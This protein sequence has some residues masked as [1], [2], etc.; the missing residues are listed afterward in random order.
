[1]MDTLAGNAPLREYADG[2]MLAAK[3]GGIGFVTF[4][5]PEKRNAMSVEMWQGLAEIL[6]DFR[7]DPAVR[8]V[9]MTG[10]G[11]Q[12][13]VCMLQGVVEFSESARF[14]A[15]LGTE[16]AA[17]SAK[18]FIISST[19]TD[20]SGLMLSRLTR[21]TAPLRT[22][23]SASIEAGNPGWMR[24]SWLSLKFA[25]THSPCAGT[26]DISCAPIVA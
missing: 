3:D 22:K 12:A 15:A 6:D 25:S 26:I 13:F 19:S 8:V 23:A 5:Q 4:N 14:Q 18:D 1:M 2:K 17:G 20:W 10:A 21:F 11:G 16:L 24:A 9:I 7:D